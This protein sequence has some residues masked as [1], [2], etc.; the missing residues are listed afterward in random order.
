MAVELLPE[1]PRVDDRLLRQ[2]R[3]AEAGREGR[4][5]LGHADLRP[6]QLRR[7]S[8]EEVEERLA[9]IE[10][11][12]R[13]QDPEGVGGQEDDRARVPRLLRGQRVRDLLELVRRPGVLRL[14]VVVEVDDAVLVDRDVFEDRP[15]GA[16]RPIDLRL[17]G[18]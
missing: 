2:E 3:R 7:E 6:G 13:R 16:S 1:H 18:R 9:P 12:D 11:S 8:G 5:R 15:E 10:P 4:L 17:G 14:R